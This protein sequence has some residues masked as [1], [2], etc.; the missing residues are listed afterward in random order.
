M[1]P[2]VWFT[3]WGRTGEVLL[4]PKS[5]DFGLKPSQ[6]N[7]HE[8]AVLSS[9]Q[10]SDWSGMNQHQHFA[11]FYE[12][13]PFLVNSLVGFVTA[14]LKASESVIVVATEDHRVQLE[15]R[16]YEC[17]TDLSAAIEAGQYIQ[18]DAAETLAK[19]M[20]NGSPDAELFSSTIS[21]IISKTQ[22]APS[23]VRIF[24]EMVALLWLQRNFEGALR[25]EELWNR[26]HRDNPF[27]LFCAY[28]VNGV[29]G[30]NITNSLS[31]IC[32]EHS[33]IIPAESYTSLTS[34]DT[35]L[36]AILELQQKAKAL[37]AEVAERKQTEHTLRMVKEELETQ[38]ADLKRLHEMNTSLA[39]SP[40]I[41]SL[42]RE[43]LRA[44][45]EVQN[46]DLGL[47]SLCESGESD[48]V[49]KV[50]CGFDESLSSGLP[51]R[52]WAACGN[53]FEEQ[54][55]VIVED[56]EDA[57]SFVFLRDFARAQG[58]R[59]CHGTPLITRNGN[60]IGVLSV[61]F[62]RTQRPSEREIRL[63]DLYA[64]MA[65]DFIDGA[66]L[67][68]QLEQQLEL[69]EELL[70]REQMARAD[71]EN[72]NRMKDEFLATVS[73]EL[74]TPLNAIIG[75]LHMIR[76][77]R[78]DQGTVDRALETI[79]RNAKA[80][81]QLIEDILDVSR[82]ITGKLRLNMGP[83][84]LATIINAAIDSV[85]PAAESKGIKLAVT[86]DPS[87]RHTIGDE[88]RLQQVVW[89]LV[90]NAIKFTPSGGVV[91]ITLARKDEGVEIRVTDSG[92]GIKGEFLP[93]IF[94]RFRQ[95]DGTSTR[96]H[97]GLG[98]GL[99]I[100]RH[101]VE[102]HGGTVHASSD[103][104]GLGS[105]FTILLPQSSRSSVSEVHEKSVESSYSVTNNVAGEPL[106]SLEDV[107]ILLVDNDRDTL[108]VLAVMLRERGARVEAATT[109]A[110]AREVLEWLKA[111]VLVSDLAMPEEDGYSLISRI[112]SANGNGNRHLP[113][114]ALTAY[115]RVEDRSRALSAGFNMF[116]PKPVQP[117]E[118][119]TAIANLA[120]SAKV[121]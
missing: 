101:L 4:N 5:D 22:K 108:Q 72:A 27:L 21:E 18:L 111:D 90:A 119:I 120:E 24:G 64:Q 9:T 14:G 12:A 91:Q 40:D 70:A 107:S 31:N 7:W 38:L 103:G 71:A 56:L 105:T 13:D 41:E 35:R 121:A 53:C 96:Q 28:P 94:D 99:A 32:A 77:G 116:V 51:S 25:L 113:A 1:H 23:S 61:Y 66:R 26:L 106:P 93:F 49:V 67:H 42:L 54:T 109:A 59:A 73:H 74:R 85:Q 29:A 33:Y 84:D 20:V 15:R 88:S 79:D 118:L 8:L 112:R 46:S 47:L 3:G 98:L 95:A 6:L 11:Q 10:V 81:A 69:R 86:L 117:N 110:E 92:S 58:I 68:H 17:G 34:P 50:Q 60:I 16:L 43:V 89:N 63:M 65:A 76:S 102:L 48:P 114:V 2:S 44:A 97:G 19:F 78:L 82:V 55:R 100:V 45:M 104:E 36:R 115:V 87:A 52:G 83:V 57:P 80:Q 30:E 75:W 62:R 37:E 39:G